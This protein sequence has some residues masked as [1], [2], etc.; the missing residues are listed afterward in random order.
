MKVKTTL[1][2]RYLDLEV[3][4]YARRVNQKYFGGGEEEE[5]KA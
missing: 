3:A 2:R 4:I 1:L 5:E